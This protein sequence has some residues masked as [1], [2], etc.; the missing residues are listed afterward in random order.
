M[1]TAMGAMETT[2]GRQNRK[3]DDGWGATITCKVSHQPA[4]PYT[5]NIYFHPIENQRLK[6]F[7][8]LFPWTAAKVCCSAPQV[9]IQRYVPN[10]RGTRITMWSHFLGPQQNDLCPTMVKR[11]QITSYNKHFTFFFSV[12]QDSEQL[13]A[14]CISNPCQLQ[15]ELVESRGFWQISRAVHVT[16]LIWNPKT[17]GFL[18]C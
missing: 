11:D 5:Y 17:W 6:G 3:V 8:W 1:P 15:L 7:Q 18:D 13:I 14:A 16:A 12:L 2:S 4:Q 9:H 10:H